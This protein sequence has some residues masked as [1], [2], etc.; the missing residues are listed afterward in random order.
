[1]QRWA[2]DLCWRSHSLWQSLSWPTMA[3]TWPS[4]W[5]VFLLLLLLLLLSLS[6]LS[7]PVPYFY[8]VLWCS[9]NTKYVELFIN[10]QGLC[11]CVWSHV[12]VCL[13]QLFIWYNILLGEEEGRTVSIR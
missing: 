3:S 8:Y 12:C 1:L 5:Q 9:V 7:F 6:L 2:E 11:V 10:T 13:C 4:F